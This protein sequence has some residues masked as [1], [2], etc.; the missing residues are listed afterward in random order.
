MLCGL[1]AMKQS[2]VLD[3]SSSLTSSVMADLA[4]IRGKPP[5]A[6]FQELLRPTVV[7]AFANPFAAAQL[8]DAIFATQTI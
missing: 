1:A 6:G 5:L 2:S 3:G 8:G 4:V 7:Q